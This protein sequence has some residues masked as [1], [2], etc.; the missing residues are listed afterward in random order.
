[1]ERILPRPP[2]TTGQLKMLGIRNVS[3]GR[4][5]EQSFGFTPQASAG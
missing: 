5:L 1:M 4:D 2:L 3:E